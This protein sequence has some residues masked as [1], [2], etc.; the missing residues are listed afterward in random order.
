MKINLTNLQ[1][2][3]E[4]PKV[5]RASKIKV[6]W[7]NYEDVLVMMKLLKEKPKTFIDVGAGYGDYIKIIRDLVPTCKI[8]S[9]DPV[10]SYNGEEIKKI[11]LSDKNEIEDFYVEDNKL[12]SSFK[13]H[14]GKTTKIKAECKRFDSLGLKIEKPAILKTDV[15]GAE[16]KVLKGFGKILKD[17]DVIQIEY[18]FDRSYNKTYDLGEAIR[19]LNGFGFY[20]FIQR[21]IRYKDGKLLNCDFVFWK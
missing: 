5:I 11:A 9:F 14:K 4:N 2:L 17:I 1:R 6:K 15:E 21:A 13:E 19:L 8:Y 16:L 10:L 20:N 7:K 3:I 18:V 12:G